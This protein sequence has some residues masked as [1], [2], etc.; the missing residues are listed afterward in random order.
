MVY[1]DSGT[2]VGDHHWRSVDEVQDGDE[3]ELDK[4]V[5]IEVGERLSTTQT[6]LTNLFEKKKSSQASPAQ[7]NQTPLQSQAPRQLTS[8][9]PPPIPSNP[10]P[11]RSSGSSQTYRSLNDLL[12]IK[13][14]TPQSSSHAEFQRPSASVQE[15]TEPAQKRQKVVATPPSIRNDHRI[16]T[17][18]PP[19]ETIPPRPVPIS[20]YPG[21]NTPIATAQIKPKRN[22]SSEVVDLTGPENECRNAKPQDSS[23]P[24]P[25]RDLNPV[26]LPPKEKPKHTPKNE[27]RLDD[28]PERPSTTK[29]MKTTMPP[30]KEK[31]KHTLENGRQVDG[32]PKPP[33]PA[34]SMIANK[35]QGSR[36]ADAPSIPP[37]KGNMQTRLNTDKEESPPLSSIASDDFLFDAPVESMPVFVQPPR[38]KLIHTA[39]LPTTKPIQNPAPKK[40]SNFP[41]PLQPAPKA[42]VPEASMDFAPS[43]STQFILEELADGPALGKNAPSKQPLNALRASV[44]KPH[45]RRNDTPLRKSLSDPSA[46]TRPVSEARPTLMRNAMSA[47]PE[48]PEAREEG[49]WTSEALDL[50][51]FWPSGRPRPG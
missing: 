36:Q 18:K 7:N 17:S 51:D 1:D 38:K 6:D 50:F 24:P 15:S 40:S 31:P 33:N 11:F 30:P 23:K 44:P 28:T 22:V 26:M 10:A 29:N 42:P 21:H 20:Q 43:D 8:T 5:L 25:A 12:G 37:S 4:G 49:P 14:A 48:E 2:F 41:K 3:L 39:L 47:V 34:S 45:S 46:L 13:K 9:A 19:S 35:P 27:K 16:E 32:P